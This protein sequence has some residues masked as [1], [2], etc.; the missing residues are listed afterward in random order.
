M[1]AERYGFEV[2]AWVDPKFYKAL[3]ADVNAAIERAVA[4][5]HERCAKIAERVATEAGDGEG[6]F[7]IARKIADAIRR[8]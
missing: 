6:E 8:S 1:P 4:K 2:S 5:E 3:R 7:Y